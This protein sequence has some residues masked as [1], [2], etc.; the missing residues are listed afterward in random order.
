MLREPSHNQSKANGQGS[1]V[2]VLRGRV[3][4]RLLRG[5]T[6]AERARICA[7]LLEHKVTFT[8]LLPAQVA[9]LVGANPGSVCVA[10]GHA[11]TRG[12]RRR[13]LER[14]IRKYGANALM[15]ELDR[16]TAPQPVAAE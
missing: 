11:G 12:P 4:Q 13:T 16:I 9:R 8:G 10:L 3:L 14:V 5:R 7:Q 6:A 15:R 1:A 2:K